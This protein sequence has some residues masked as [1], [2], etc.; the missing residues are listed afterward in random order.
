[1]NFDHDCQTALVPL[2]IISNPTFL[3]WYIEINDWMRDLLPK[4]FPEYSLKLTKI[5]LFNFESFRRF[6]VNEMFFIFVILFDWKRNDIESMFEILI[7][8][9]ISC[10]Y[11]SIICKIFE[12][13]K[14]FYWIDQWLFSL[15]FKNCFIVYSTTFNWYSI[16]RE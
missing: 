5:F 13:R 7:I 10:W 4:D 9:R 2:S 14:D 1:M 3:F 15:I 12:K 16:L 11:Y 6:N 8:E